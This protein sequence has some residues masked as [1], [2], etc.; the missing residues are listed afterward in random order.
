MVTECGGIFFN[1]EDTSGWGYTNAERGELI[2]LHRCSPDPPSAGHLRESDH[3]GGLLS[4]ALRAAKM[5][6][7]LEKQGFLCYTSFGGI[8]QFTGSR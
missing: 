6:A 3:K 1:V 5:P 4:F 8:R 2:A 7:V